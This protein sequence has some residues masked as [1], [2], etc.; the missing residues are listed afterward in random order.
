MPAPHR[1]RALA[2]PDPG[3]SPA[4]AAPTLDENS[5]AKVERVK[6]NPSSRK[7]TPESRRARAQLPSW[8]ADRRPPAVPSRPPGDSAGH[9]GR[10]CFRPWGRGEGGALL[11]LAQF[12]RGM[13]LAAAC[14]ETT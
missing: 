13:G 4:D 6:R 9:K 12:V 10:F 2:A 8:A 14:R 11:S 5:I 1:I 3:Q 7:P